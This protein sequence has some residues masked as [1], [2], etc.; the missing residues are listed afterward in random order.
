MEATIRSHLLRFLCL[1]FCCG[2]LGCA[3]QGPRSQL[4]LSNPKQAENR[5]MRFSVNRAKE[6]E[7][8]LIEAREGYL[9]LYRAAP[10]DAEVC[11][12]LGVTMIRMGQ[13]DDGITY[14]MEADALTNGDSE[15]KG[16]LGYAYIQ[17]GDYQLAESFLREALNINPNDVRSTN[18]LALAVGFQ[19]NLSDAYALYRGV[20]TDA[21]ANANL[22]YIHAQRGEAVEALRRYNNALSKNPDLT[23]AAE[24]LVQLVE[25][26]TEV[27]KLQKTSPSAARIQLA[28]GVAE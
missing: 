7:G 15:I 9:E 22:G 21:E 26:Q 27:A 12:R 13:V 4:S 16:D 28:N 23:I 10:D 18:N 5:G 19:G 14:L 3:S 2:F 17:K 8:N 20:M 25:I 11:H 6:A 24:G 1:T